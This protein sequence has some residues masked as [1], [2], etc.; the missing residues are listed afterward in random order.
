MG[1]LGVWQGSGLI[2]KRGFRQPNVSGFGTLSGVPG[3]VYRI[4]GRSRGVS[5]VGGRGDR[6]LSIYWH[7]Q[8]QVEHRTVVFIHAVSSYR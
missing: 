7:R 5:A 6:S 1:G 3:R 2:G 4:Q 8:G